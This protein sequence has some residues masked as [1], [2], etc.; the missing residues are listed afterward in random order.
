MSESCVQNPVTD[1]QPVLLLK[2]ALLLVNRRVAVLWIAA[3]A[4]VVAGGV[5]ILW[6]NYYV[7][8]LKV[9]PSKDA[10]LYMWALQSNMLVDA[11]A[12]K[13][14]LGSHY[15]QSSL[16]ALHGT[17]KRR[18]TILNNPRDG[19]IDV[20]VEDASPDYAANIANEYG[21]QMVSMLSS[22][23]LT[24][25]DRQLYTLQT[26]R[27]A[28]QLEKQ[29][30]LK[31]LDKPDAKSLLAQISIA[32]KLSISSM[33]A[34][35]AE[36][37]LSDEKIG[38]LT[39]N[40]FVRVQERLSTIQR[41]LVENL[42]KNR[43]DSANAGQLFVAVDALQNSAYWGT[44]VDRMD[45]RISLLQAQKKVEVK[46]IPAEKADEEAGPAR[47]RLAAMLFGMGIVIALIYVF[48]AEALAQFRK[49]IVGNQLL[50]QISIVFTQKK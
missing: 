24:D 40:E 37:T 33:A 29:A 34:I 27:D 46:I 42:Q 19:N 49:T 35:Q 22:L 28:A 30:I 18:V 39:Q 47:G 8:T 9:A 23:R 5:A 7:A 21:A 4:F 11:V 25:L 16:V 45:Q 14:D 50:N 43:K 1:E 17:L 13:L 10:P 44:L 3:V 2:L 12:T 20:T 48:L 41:I 15:N 32:D 6:P 31:V 26:K 36:A 38:D